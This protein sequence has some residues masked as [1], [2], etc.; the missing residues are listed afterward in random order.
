MVRLCRGGVRGYRMIGG[1]ASASWLGY[2]KAHNSWSDYTFAL[3]KA[4]RSKHRLMHHGPWT[5]LKKLSS[6]IELACCRSAIIGRLIGLSC[7]IR[8]QIFHEHLWSHNA[9]QCAAWNILCYQRSISSDIDQDKLFI[10]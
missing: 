1:L 10:S 6:R 8:E 5:K 7:N 3:T 4:S 9:G 2:D